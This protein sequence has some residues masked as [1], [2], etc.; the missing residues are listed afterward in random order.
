MLQFDWPKLWDDNVMTA[1]KRSLEATLQSELSRNPSELIR[2]TAIVEDL[3]FGSLPPHVALSSIREL[4]PSHTAVVV[5]IKYSG[6]ASI[7]LKGLQINLDTTTFVND[8]G[9]DA[10]HA[11]PFYCP[12]EMRLVGIV[13]E[14]NILV[15]VCTSTEEVPQT[16]PQ[17]P[18]PLHGRREGGAG[19]GGN[20]S[21]LIGR[22]LPSHVLNAT[23]SRGYGSSETPRGTSTAAGSRAVSP[24]SA[25]VPRF[26]AAHISTNNGAR[27]SSFTRRTTG[28]IGLLFGAGGRRGMRHPD[29]PVSEFGSPSRWPSGEGSSSFASDVAAMTQTSLQHSH[30]MTNA[31]TTSANTQTHSFLLSDLIQKRVRIVNKTLTLQFFGDPIREF[32][33]ESNFA[34]VQGANE[35]IGAQLRSIIAPTIE[36]LKTEGFTIHL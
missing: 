29:A 5:S 15:E 25:S 23:S 22:L 20:T 12:F 34:P 16:S 4:S 7:A 19:G 28:G 17:H 27:A 14:G 32:T 21:I 9:E 2:G 33:V 30:M 11:V 31:A 24:V 18:S 35:K 26:D 1:I 13:I 6:D 10:N 3:N 8:K 36:R